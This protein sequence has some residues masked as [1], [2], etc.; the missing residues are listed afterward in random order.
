M[1][2][3]DLIDISFLIKSLRWTKI[4]LHLNSYKIIKLISINHASMRFFKF[5][6]QILNTMSHHDGFSINVP[7]YLNN[8]YSISLVYELIILYWSIYIV[9]IQK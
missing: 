8:C 6:H 3:A 4:T 5:D 7:M 2:D 1:Y 9:Y